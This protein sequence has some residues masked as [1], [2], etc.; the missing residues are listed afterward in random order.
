MKT[1][2][3]WIDQVYRIYHRYRNILKIIDSKVSTKIVIKSVL[4][5]LLISL[6]IVLIPVLVTVNLFI[7]NKLDL[8]LSFVL[9]FILTSWGFLFFHFYYTLLKSY[10][11]ELEHVNVKLPKL[12]EGTSVSFFLFVLGIIVVSVIF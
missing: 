12:I 2:S 5:S 10:E 7:Y 4:F 6:L 8:I 3:K 1:L 9:L 11:T